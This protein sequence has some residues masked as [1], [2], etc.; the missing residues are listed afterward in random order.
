MCGKI[1]I[2]GHNILAGFTTGFAICER[3]FQ[4]EINQTILLFD[5][6]DNFDI[7]DAKKHIFTVCI[8]VFA[9][10]VV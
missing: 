2:A 3:K 8:G 7:I 1:T 4:N 9:S 10:V 5:S 6:L